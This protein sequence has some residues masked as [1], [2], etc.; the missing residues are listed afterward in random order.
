MTFTTCT[1]ILPYAYLTGFH[2]R[3]MPGFSPPQR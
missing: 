1:H 3:L 2:P